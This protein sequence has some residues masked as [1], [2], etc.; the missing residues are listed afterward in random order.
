[1]FNFRQGQDFSFHIVQ[2]ASKAHP[3]AY[4]MGTMG[5]SAGVKQPDREAD[6]SY[7]SSA[8]DNSEA[9]LPLSHT[10]SWRGD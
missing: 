7:P 3:A 8:E 4:P 6:F 9:I 5:L 10:S 1:V 2:I